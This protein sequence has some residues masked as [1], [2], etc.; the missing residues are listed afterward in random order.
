VAR[1]LSRAYLAGQGLG[2][3]FIDYVASIWKRFMAD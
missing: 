2:P 1:P 3:V